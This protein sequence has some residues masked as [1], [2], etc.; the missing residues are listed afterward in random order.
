VVKEQLG[1]KT[2][3]QDSDD[4]AMMFR[5]TYQTPFYRAI[6]AL[7]HDEV[8]AGPNPTEDLCRRLDARWDELKRTER[9]QRSTA[10]DNA[11]MAT[12]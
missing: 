7:L 11:G 6:R 12:S 10:T 3:W 4:L 5:G 2:N 8:D 1:R 9:A